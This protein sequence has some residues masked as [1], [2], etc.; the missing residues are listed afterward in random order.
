MKKSARRPGGPLTLT[1]NRA[2]RD[3]G[4]VVLRRAVSPACP[5]GQGCSAAVAPARSLRG[6]GG[7]FGKK[8]RKDAATGGVRQPRKEHFHG[9]EICRSARTEG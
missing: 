3:P 6:A 1:L 8:T 7:V 4:H 2:I 9:T 5:A